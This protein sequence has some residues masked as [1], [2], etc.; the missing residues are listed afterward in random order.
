MFEKLKLKAKSILFDACELIGKDKYFYEDYGKEFVDYYLQFNEDSFELLKSLLLGKFEEI[1]VEPEDLEK[2]LYNPGSTFII[3]I[4][5]VD[6]TK[7]RMGKSN[8]TVIMKSIVKDPKER[9]KTIMREI[10]M[11]KKRWK[12]IA[13]RLEDYYISFDTLDYLSKSIVYYISCYLFHIKRVEKLNKKYG[14]KYLYN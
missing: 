6:Y 7:L 4:L 9:A 8:E 5:L 13:D 3:N 14:M 11:F 12:E 1:K 2:D 10:S